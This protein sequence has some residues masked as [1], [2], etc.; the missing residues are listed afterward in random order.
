MVIHDRLRAFYDFYHEIN[1]P[2]KWYL[3][4]AIAFAY[5]GISLGVEDLAGDIFVNT[6]LMGKFKI[7]KK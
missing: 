4:A 6:V 1:H 2:K 3:W 7:H 5:Y